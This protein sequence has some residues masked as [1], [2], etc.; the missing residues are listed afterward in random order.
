MSNNK[1]QRFII[2]H[3][4]NSLRW[5]QPKGSK[6][7]QDSILNWSVIGYS[8]QHSGADQD[9]RQLRPLASILASPASYKGRSIPLFL[10]VK[11]WPCSINSP[12]ATVMS[13]LLDDV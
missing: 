3:M 2:Y 13:P 1:L 8:D 4:Q 11:Y 5:V 6:I 12:D 7:D 9:G 10:Q